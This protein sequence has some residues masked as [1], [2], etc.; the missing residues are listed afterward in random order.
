MEPSQQVQSLAFFAKA[1]VIA[2]TVRKYRGRCAI[3]ITYESEERSAVIYGLKKVKSAFLDFKGVITV[4]VK[5][6]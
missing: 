6:T 2:N 5:G 3:C 1:Q 4:N